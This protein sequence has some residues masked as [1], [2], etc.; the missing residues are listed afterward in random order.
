MDIQEGAAGF[1]LSN[2]PTIV[3][4]CLQASL[5]IFTRAGIENIVNKSI[6]LTG[7][8]ELLLKQD[9]VLKSKYEVIYVLYI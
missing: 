6:L 1:Q 8:M 2:P 7:Y 5:D 9:K 4:A 3:L